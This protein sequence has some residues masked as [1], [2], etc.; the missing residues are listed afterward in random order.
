MEEQGLG[1][2]RGDQIFKWLWQKDVSDF[3]LMTDI[4]RTWRKRLKQE[5]SI[6]GLDLI[7]RRKAPDK[8]QKFLFRTQDNRY[9]ES[10]FIPEQRRQTI[11]VS[12][13]IGCALGCRFCATGLIPLQRNLAGYEIA[14]QIQIIKRCV[15]SPITNIV[16]MGM[17]EPLLNLGGLFESLEIICSSLGFGIGQ[18]RITVS[19]AGIIE[20]MEILLKS[21]YK[22]KLAISLNFVNQD[23]RAAMM[24]V[25]RKNPLKEL[26]KLA[27]KYSYEKHRVTFE[28]VLI[29]KIN[30]S[31]QDARELLRLIKN[32]PSK[33]NLISYNPHP[34]LPF[35]RP[36]T[37]RIEQFYQYL[38]SSSHTV[39][40]RKSRGGKILAGCGQ[41]AL[42]LTNTKNPL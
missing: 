38:L 11:C 10:V 5:F 23:L 15:A 7:K 41:L 36:E 22:V 13:Q 1:A 19:T 39:V 40:L 35:K 25:A 27:R 14:E 20:G 29:H 4:A 17:G 30:D 21:R 31:L 2:Y 32:I 18:R 6:V 24:P 28:Y 3:E 8:S 33:I 42:D 34:R 26:L 12:S 16:F 9:L 37:K